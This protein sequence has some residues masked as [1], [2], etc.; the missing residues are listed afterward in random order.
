MS[1]I[2]ELRNKVKAQTETITA[3][4]QELEHTNRETDREIR[5][6]SMEKDAI[7]KC[8]Q[9]EMFNV[10]ILNARPPQDNNLNGDLLNEKTHL[11]VEIR[12]ISRENTKFKERMKTITVS[13][14]AAN[15]EIL[16]LRRK[17]SSARPSPS[18]N[19]RP[20]FY[21][22]RSL[23]YTLNEGS[24]RSSPFKRETLLPGLLQR[25][26]CLNAE[27]LEAS[28]QHEFLVATYLKSSSTHMKRGLEV[29][30]TQITALEAE[31]RQVEASI[32]LHNNDF[33]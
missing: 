2:T 30:E 22:V 3:L 18:L 8:L 19:R 31:K 4:E 10:E 33:Q 27:I 23:C 26:S 15:R 17:N 29:L 28:S 9:H 24:T 20:S 1:E 16:K 7:F 25:F 13:L 11:E 21:S 5:E 32:C 14:D 6:L 12:R